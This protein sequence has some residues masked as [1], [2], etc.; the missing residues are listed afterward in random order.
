MADQSI[1]E[2]KLKLKTESTNELNVFNSIWIDFSLI[3]SV[4]SALIPPFPFTKY[5]YGLSL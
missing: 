5:A 4:D 2:V 3:N 1:A